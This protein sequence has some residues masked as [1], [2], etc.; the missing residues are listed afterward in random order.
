MVN[1]R[2]LALAAT[3]AVSAS[4]AGGCVAHAGVGAEATVYDPGPRMVYVSPGLWVVEDYHASIFYSD[5]YYWRNTGG[6]WYRSSYYNDG[7]VRVRVLPTR[8]RRVRRP[9][10]YVRYR[11]PRGVRYKRVRAH[12]KSRHKASKARR[13]ANKKARKNERKRAK[14]RDKR[15]KKRDKARRKYD[16]DR[17]D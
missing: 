8:I 14:D 5:G 12:P 16:R 6:Y 7:F 9:H 2:N 4:L 11:G 10:A 1:I 3:I 13:K 15:R 17:R